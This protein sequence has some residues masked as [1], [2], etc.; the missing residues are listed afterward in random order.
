MG[1]SEY[2]ELECVCPL[3]D[4]IVYITREDSDIQTNDQVWFVY[5]GHCE[6]CL[7]KYKL[8]IENSEEAN[9]VKPHD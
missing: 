2:V 9:Q 6:S 3:C 8:L 4:I 7:R 5:E 1:L